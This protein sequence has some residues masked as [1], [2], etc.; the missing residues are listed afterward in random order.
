[1]HLNSS[2]I[3]YRLYIICML[4]AVHSMIHEFFTKILW[5]H[6]FFNTKNVF[7]TCRTLRHKR[8]SW[9]YNRHTLVFVPLVEFR[10]LRFS[11]LLLRCY[12]N[13]CRDSQLS[14]H[15]THFRKKRSW[16]SNSRRL[17]MFCS[18]TATAH[19]WSSARTREALK[20][21]W[22]AYVTVHILISPQGL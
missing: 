7:K 2:I 18:F 21:F 6:L 20:R 11:R 10:E 16:T 13:G 22:R 17:W 4:D 5:F 15:G 14:C 8:F 3:A 19:Y 1:M 9:V 12:T